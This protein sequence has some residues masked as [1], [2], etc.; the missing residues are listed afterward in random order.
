M[1]LANP[2]DGTFLSRH[3][4]VLERTA[5]NNYLR[6]GC[7][8]TGILSCVLLNELD[9]GVIV[10]CRKMVHTEGSLC[11]DVSQISFVWATLRDSP[12]YALRKLGE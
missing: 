1:I 12:T 7:D 9:V 6:G 8:L 10:E 4:T 2:Q 11:D 3:V 5:R